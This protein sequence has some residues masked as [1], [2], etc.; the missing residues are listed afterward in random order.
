M[1]WLKFSGFLTRSLLK[2]MSHNNDHSLLII[3]LFILF[4]GAFIIFGLGYILFYTVVGIA[5][6][7]YIFFVPLLIIGVIILIARALKNNIKGQKIPANTVKYAPKQPT[8][9]ENIK[10]TDYD[11]DVSPD[12]FNGPEEDEEK[13]RIMGEYDLDE[14]D[15]EK[16]QEIAEEW[17]I[18]EDKAAELID[19]L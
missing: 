15:A 19:D 4:P 7:I 3:I 9:L 14:D 2:N 12:N 17:G 8:L 11:T 6:L 5:Y 13:Q 1:L 18:D 16:V 10:S